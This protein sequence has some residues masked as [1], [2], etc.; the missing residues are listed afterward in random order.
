MFS[1]DLK[2]V[3]LIDLGLSKKLINDTCKTIDNLKGTS[4]YL[5]PD[6]LKYKLAFKNDIW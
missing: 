6:Q 4:R 3:K 1:K 2:T 5:S